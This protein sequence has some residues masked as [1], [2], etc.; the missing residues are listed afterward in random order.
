MTELRQ[1]E[2]RQARLRAGASRLAALLATGWKIPE[3]F[4]AK[5]RDGKTDIHG[6]IFRPTNF[7][8]TRSIR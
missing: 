3:R 8:P 5:G 4:V 6:V 1:V 2:R 7:D